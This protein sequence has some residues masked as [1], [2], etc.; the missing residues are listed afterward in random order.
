MANFSEKVYAFI[1][2]IFRFGL[3]VTSVA[4][5][6]NSGVV[7]FKN[8]DDS[9]YVIV[10]VKAPVADN[11]A[12]TKYYADSLEK[13]LIVKRQA[14][15]SAALPANT[16]VRGWVV[17]TTA[18]TGAAVGDVLYD[19]GTGVGNMTIVAAIEGRTIAVT[20]ALSGGTVTFFADTV[21][22]WDDDGTQ[23]IMI[24]GPGTG[25]NKVV[26]YVLDN[27]AAQDSVW[28]IPANCRILRAHIEITTPYSAG[29][30]ISLGQVGSVA[31]LMATTDL[32]AQTTGIYEVPQD[33]SW[34][35]SDLVVRTT[36]SGAPAAGAG[37]AVVEYAYP[38]V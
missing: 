30:T 10:R 33:T 37:V 36:V 25:A 3:G 34:G 7:E 14:D 18:G 11:D 15:C 29:G 26:R 12:V 28:L 8:Y 32:D 35:G 31:L 1:G 21:Y 19:D 4:L 2:S 27:T 5:K 22:V 20:D 17:V 23:W 13:P 6:N 9:D 38:L 24:G 16:G